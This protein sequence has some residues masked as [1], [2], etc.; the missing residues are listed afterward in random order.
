MDYPRVGVSAIVLNDISQILMGKRKGSHGAGTWSFPGGWL[1]YGE[2][3]YIAVKRE[4]MEECG[5]DVHIL[6]RGPYTNDI[7]TEEEHGKN[8]HCLTLFFLAYTSGTPELR[9]PEKCEEWGWFHYNELPTPLFLPVENYLWAYG[10]KKNL[11]LQGF[12][13]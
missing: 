8:L 6:N 11:I 9:E 2:N 3:P 12:A 7:F 1:E 10:D 4:C 5:L 13:R